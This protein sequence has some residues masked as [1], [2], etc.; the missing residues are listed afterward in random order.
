[1]KDLQADLTADLMADLGRPA[2]LPAATPLAPLPELPRTS[3]TPAL[4]LTVTPLRW[5]RPGLAA[6]ERGAGLA[7]RLGPLRVEVAF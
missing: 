1:M 5:S 2:P 3:G 4:A 7:V 6:A